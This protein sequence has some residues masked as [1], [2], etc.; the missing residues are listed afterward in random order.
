MK[1]KERNRNRFVRHRH[2]RHAMAPASASL[3]VARGADGA[4]LMAST[5]PGD[6]Q[7]RLV[8][9]D[10]LTGELQVH[11]ARG[12][13]RFASEA[14]ACQAMKTRH[15]AKDGDF[16]RAKCILGAKVVAG[17]AL[18]LVAVRTRVCATLPGGV[19]EVLAVEESRWITTTLRAPGKNASKE[20][21]KKLNALLEH[22]LDG[23]HFVCLTEDLSAPFGSSPEQV[24]TSSGEFGAHMHNFKNEFVWNSLWKES[25]QHLGLSRHCQTL[26]QGLVESRTLVD[27]MGTEWHYCLLSKRSKL[28]P[29][30]RYIAR[31]LNQENSPGNE[32]ECQQLVWRVDESGRTRWSNLI[33]RRGTVP[34]WWGQEIKS[35][36][37]EALI[38]VSETPY[39][40][41]EKYFQRI[42]HLYHLDS[43]AQGT[44]P[45]TCINLLRCSPGKPELLLSEHFHQGVRVAK[46]KSKDLDL[47]MLNFDWHGN[48]KSMGEADAVE[49]FWSSIH[50]CAKE[51]GYQVGEL[52]TDSKLVTKQMQRG[53]LRFNCA[54]SLDRTNLASFFY[55]IQLLVEQCKALGLNIAAKQDSYSME[56]TEMQGFQGVSAV[57][58]PLP[59]GW[60]ARVDNSSG[61]TFYVDHNTRTTTW[62]R[63][64]PVV[65]DV[66]GG[67]DQTS[68]SANSVDVAFGLFRQSVQRFRARVSPTVVSTVADIF[69]LNGD[70]NAMCYTGSKAMHSSVINILKGP[71][72]SASRLALASNAAISVQRRYLNMVEDS[73][74]QLQIELFLGMR[75]REYF[76]TILRQRHH[77]LSRP[78][79]AFLLKPV[80]FFSSAR[81]SLD[82]LLLPVEPL[83]QWMCPADIGQVSLYILLSQPCCVR[84][85][86]I[87]AR[88]GVADTASPHRFS[89]RMGPYL[90]QMHDAG[91]DILLPRTES[92]I[93]MAFPVSKRSGKA[94]GRASCGP[95]ALYPY[96][97]DPVHTD[98]LTRIVC[99]TFADLP[100]TGIGNLM[101]GEVEIVGDCLFKKTEQEITEL[102]SDS[103][104]VHD[105]VNASYPKSS[106]ARELKGKLEQCNLE[107]GAGNCPYKDTVLDFKRRLGLGLHGGQSRDVSL[108]ECL[109]AEIVRL[110]A[111]ISCAERDQL[112]V[113]NEL[114]PRIFDPNRLIPAS[115]ITDIR[116]LYTEFVERDLAGQGFESMQ[117][118]VDHFQ[119]AGLIN[120][121]GEKAALLLEQ[122]LKQAA[123]NM[124][125]RLFKESRSTRH[126]L[127]LLHKGKES[128][129]KHRFQH[130]CS[131]AEYP[132][133]ALINRVPHSKAPAEVLLCSVGHQFGWMAPAGLKEVELVIALSSEAQIEQIGI[134]ADRIGYSKSDCPVVDLFV[135][136]TLAGPRQRIGSWNVL[137]NHDKIPPHTL[138]FFTFTSPT[139]CRFL[140]LIFRLPTL[141]P[142]AL[143]DAE[144]NGRV[145]GITEPRLHAG[146]VIVLGKA[147][148]SSLEEAMKL[149]ASDH[150]RI[151]RAAETPMHLT[152]SFV[153]PMMEDLS[154][155]GRTIDMMLPQGV[156][157]VSGFQLTVSAV[158]GARNILCTEYGIP[159]L[160]IRVSTRAIQGAEGS[161]ML[162]QGADS[163]AI[164]CK[165]P[166]VREG[167]LLLYDFTQPLQGSCIRFELMVHQ[168]PAPAVSYWPSGPGNLSLA[169]LVRLYCFRPRKQ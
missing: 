152:R 83:F 43:Q 136:T 11:E 76:P 146:R 79:G 100:A 52:S 137:G 96:R 107:E 106:E 49:G 68:S 168:M 140:W 18:V 69:L 51:A 105:A 85:I 150:L 61:R 167:A 65:G 143:I 144:P 139:R 156:E 104:E 82:A 132:A 9:L 64:A 109:S 145:P 66:L 1:R 155:G 75:W 166:V 26:Y 99:L 130:L 17:Q 34:I 81:V 160:L 47:R 63:P 153:T 60:E 44:F 73:S 117:V 98:F 128:E 114:E 46:T 116:D 39:Q 157:W 24:D 19:H 120:A 5:V 122:L 149:G 57:H 86:N 142:P 161:P 125:Q 134:L 87:T 135:G 165:V 113:A 133:A 20:E 108:E 129:L 54:D 4:L 45:L 89:I 29:G 53:M 37:G 110:K 115:K 163:Q 101:L 123:E 91:K 90:D 32:V 50:S 38:T 31:G 112:L 2:V 131:L 23:M 88:H 127:A 8:R 164:H 72:K 118:K 151:K 56:T 84:Y 67:K 48:V 74:R 77:V 10:P 97:H 78:P 93:S 33:W 103:T 36:M 94:E 95:K 62:K 80:P 14:A 42:K 138:T 7:T 121:V 41:T 162:E 21:K 59:P 119:R 169:G 30:T 40:G 28:H 58:A 92:G 148:Q 147:I 158:M 159:T 16:L 70:L 55:C 35:T 13:G 154:H 141:D 3:A 22:S 102:L 111:G 126:F 25:F 15:G 27:R 124:Q 12:I 71:K 6:P